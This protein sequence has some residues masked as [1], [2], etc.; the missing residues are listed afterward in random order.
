MYK[1]EDYG[2]IGGESEK[3]S[4]REIMLEIMHNGPVV[5]NFEPTFAFSYYEGGIYHSKEANDW[6]EG[7]E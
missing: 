7:L 1:V 5:M 2:Y 6:I 4:E 3:A